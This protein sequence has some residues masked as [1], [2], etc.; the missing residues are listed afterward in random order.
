MP[1]HT[2]IARSLTWS[3]L[4]AAEVAQL[5]DRVGLDVVDFPDWGNESHVHLLNRT[6]WSRLPTVIHLHGPLSMLAE[7]IGW[8]EPGSDLQRIGTAIEGAAC[9]WPTR[10]SRRVSVRPTGWRVATASTFAA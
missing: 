5:N 4:V 8:P 6:P 9:D 7:R 1:L 10:S 3:A 2:E